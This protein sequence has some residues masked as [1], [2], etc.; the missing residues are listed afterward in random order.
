MDLSVT[1]NSE[2]EKVFQSPTFV[3]SSRGVLVERRLPTIEIVLGRLDSILSSLLAFLLVGLE[4]LRQDKR[5]TG[6][7]QS[8]SLPI[9]LSMQLESLVSSH[10]I[11]LLS[12]RGSHLH[13]DLVS[14]LRRREGVSTTFSASAQLRVVSPPYFPPM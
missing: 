8:F 1:E 7:R 9:S 13:G 2:Y 4:L 10:F 6:H 12:C 5:C 11:S 3:S 14:G